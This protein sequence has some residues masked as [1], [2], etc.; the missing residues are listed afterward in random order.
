MQ[1]K[2]KNSIFI[3]SFLIILLTISPC[4]VRKSLQHA[5]GIKITNTLNK[6]NTTIQ[7]C[8]QCNFEYNL[9]Q[10]SKVENDHENTLN[11]SSAIL[12]QNHQTYY[13]SFPITFFT[14]NAASE[15]NNP[16]PLYI[17]YK[18]LKYMI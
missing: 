14:L 3:V 9:I 16:I 2:G 17:L 1:R 15:K 10:N 11:F 13:L 6:S 5:F 18:R 8:S 7:D 4:S 12:I